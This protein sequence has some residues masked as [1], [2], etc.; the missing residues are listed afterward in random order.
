MRAAPCSTM[1][2]MHSRVV[3]KSFIC[4]SLRKL[5]Q[6]FHADKSLPPHSG[7]VRK[8]WMQVPVS[9]LFAN[10]SGSAHSNKAP[11][12]EKVP[13]ASKSRACRWIKSSAIFKQRFP[14]LNEWNPMHNSSALS[15][16]ACKILLALAMSL[17]LGAQHGL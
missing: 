3:T 1:R 4:S 12:A 16:P 6:S 5:D 9:S 13:S 14:T 11:A 7:I 15:L 2:A 8:S 17:G 10:D